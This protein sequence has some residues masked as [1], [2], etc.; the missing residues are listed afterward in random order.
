M[1]FHVARDGQPIG[2]FSES[3]LR[4]KIFSNEILP[5]DHK[6]GSKYPISPHAPVLILC[7]PETLTPRNPV[8]RSN[9][10]LRPEYAVARNRDS[11]NSCGA[12]RS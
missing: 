12:V 3:E 10:A 2:E 4:Q 11:V 7:Y 5:E 1:M 8:S 9:V 6:G